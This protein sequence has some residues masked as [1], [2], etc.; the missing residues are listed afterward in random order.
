MKI[1]ISEIDTSWKP[2]DMEALI[3]IDTWHCPIRIFGTYDSDDGQVDEITEVRAVLNEDG[4]EVDLPVA[5]IERSAL[6][7]AILEWQKEE[8]L[9]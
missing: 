8:G 7:D 5:N 2:G 9:K 4:Y 6:N 3:E 1:K